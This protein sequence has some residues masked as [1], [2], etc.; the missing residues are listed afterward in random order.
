[1]HGADVAGEGL[2]GEVLEVGVLEA[3]V[4]DLVL[5]ALA[6]LLADV[7]PLDG[8]PALLQAPQHRG[9]LTGVQEQHRLPV[10]VVPR[11]PPHP[12]DVR[13]HVLGAIHLADPVHGREV[14]A[15]RHHVRGE[16]AGVLG[17]REAR[18]DLEPRHLLLPPVQVQQLDAGLQVPQAFVRETHLLAGGEEDDH[19]A[20]EVRLDEPVERV[21]LLGERRH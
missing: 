3:H 20:L 5:D 15:A 19:L 7:D 10:L 6:L 11:R 18:R 16:Q 21:Q 2:L 12:V 9:L 14:H 13:V 1:M 17:G 4:L 8:D